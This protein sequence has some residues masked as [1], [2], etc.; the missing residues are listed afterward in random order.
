MKKETIGA[1]RNR[2]VG[3]AK[4]LEHI[5][6]N[7]IESAETLL[8]VSQDAQ[9]YLTYS[10]SINLLASQALELL[11]KCLIATRICL[12]KN[13]DP[14][15]E[16]H[17]VINKKFRCL[18]HDISAIFNEPEISELKNV[19]DITNIERINNKIDSNVF[20]DEFRLKL[21]N[22]K[23]IRIKNLEAGRYGSFSKNI[24]IGGNTPSDMIHTVDFLK[25]LPDSVEKIRAEMVN[26]FN[27]KN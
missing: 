23:V 8:K 24:D 2:V 3:E 27:K 5:G 10:A 21:D 26:A 6:C 19:L 17:K 9:E 22:G 1:G 25:K 7:F 4:Y 15:E 16:I 13:N 18:G 11:P 20:I 12:D 14:L